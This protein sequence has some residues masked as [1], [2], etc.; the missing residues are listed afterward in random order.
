MQTDAGDCRHIQTN[1]EGCRQVKTLADCGLALLNMAL[2]CSRSALV[3]LFADFLFPG[4]FPF[5]VGCCT[6]ESTFVS[7]FFLHLMHSLN[8]NSKWCLHPGAAH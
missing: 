7:I 1:V 4:F 5:G 2:I 8:S 3:L 6:T